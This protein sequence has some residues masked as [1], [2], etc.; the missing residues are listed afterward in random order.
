MRQMAKAPA[1][2]TIEARITRSHSTLAG[3]LAN[4]REDSTP[5]LPD[6]TREIRGFRVSLTRDLGMNRMSGRGAFIDSVIDAVTLYYRD[7]LQNLTAWR[8]RPPKLRAAEG[9]V[10]SELAEIP[11]AIEDALD[12]AQ[13]EAGEG[14]D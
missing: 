9:P 12:T 1:D 14:H 10:E 13:N 11:P 4:L 6:A 8:A 5:L 7:V 2:T 3:S